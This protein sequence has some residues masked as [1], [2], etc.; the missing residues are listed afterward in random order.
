[1]E[2]SG[3]YYFTFIST[4]IVVQ[5]KHREIFLCSLSIPYLS[6]VFSHELTHLIFSDFAS[7]RYIPLWLN[8]GLAN[9]ESGTIG[10]ANELLERKLKEGGFIPIDKLSQFRTY[11]GGEEEMSLFYAESEKLV[12]FLITQHGRS[13]FGDFCRLIIADRS[14]EESMKEV[15]GNKYSTFH[16]FQEAWVEYIVK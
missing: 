7:G 2:D 4:G 12:E 11:P 6:V 5:D 16:D 10:Y 14:F 15:Y 13:S 8:E 3:R 1:M 9:Y